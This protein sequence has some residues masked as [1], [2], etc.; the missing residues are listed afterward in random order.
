[1]SGLSLGV[2]VPNLKFVSSTILK[3]LAFNAQILR[4]H[5][6]LATPP[7]TSFNIR[8]LAA[9]NGHRLNYEPL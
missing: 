1:M 2:S 3:L 9:A 6:T 8:G 5:V 4:G 7:F